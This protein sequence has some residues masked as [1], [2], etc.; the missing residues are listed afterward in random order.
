M[1]TLVAFHNSYHLL[2]L[3]FSIRKID[4][5]QSITILQHFIFSKNLLDTNPPPH[6]PVGNYKFKV[7]NRNTRTRCEIC[8][9]LTIKTPERR[10]VLV[11]LFLTLNTFTPCSSLSL[12][13]FE[14]VN[15]RWYPS[16]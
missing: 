10:H 15:A 4:N 9:K 13:N 6:I 1:E 12:V 7:N 2:S 8:S 14:Q 5:L 16:L 11:A 3:A